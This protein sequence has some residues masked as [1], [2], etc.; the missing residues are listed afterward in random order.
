MN[1]NPLA[2]RGYILEQ[3]FFNRL[4]AQQLARIREESRREKISRELGDELA[5]DDAPLLDSLIELGI[6]SDIAAAFEALPLVEVAW[7]DG[8]VDYEERWRVLELATAVGLELGRP[9]HAQLELW[10]RE[11]PEEDLFDAWYEFAASALATPAS[12]AR[13]RR[14]LEGALE[15]A[16]VA[17]GMLG[18]WK[19][20]NSERAVI[21]RIRRALSG[22]TP[23]AGLN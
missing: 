21:D 9:A 23:P 1:A 8:D 5:I 14:I 6:R 10:L 4:Q 17:G 20:S 15:V 22:S 7:A 18:F 13:S 16:S 2:G 3:D 11:R 19:V 12:A